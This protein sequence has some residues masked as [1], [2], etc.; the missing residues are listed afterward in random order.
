MANQKRT[1]FGTFKLNFRQKANGEGYNRE[2][3]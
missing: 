2:D 1:A 3:A